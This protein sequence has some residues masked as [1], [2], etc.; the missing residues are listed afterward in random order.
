MHMP[1]RQRVHPEGARDLGGETR[2]HRAV[3]VA[4][5]VGELHLL[6]PT[7][8]R[9]GVLDH[10]RVEAVGDFVAEALDVEA[11]LAVRRIDLRKNRVQVEIVE[12]LGPAADLAEQLGA[13]DDFVQ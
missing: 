2:A 10:P 3:C 6:A 11:A 5:R 9:L 1:I 13:P 8:H 7:E 12:M 4:N